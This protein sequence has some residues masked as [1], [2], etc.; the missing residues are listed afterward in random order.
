M[1]NSIQTDIGIYDLIFRIAKPV[2]ISRARWIRTR[3][4]LNISGHYIARASG[5]AQFKTR[6]SEIFRLA[7]EF[8]AG[9]R[10]LA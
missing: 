4:A 7:H 2:G 10:V 8:G 9:K 5:E 3:R 1:F 6:V